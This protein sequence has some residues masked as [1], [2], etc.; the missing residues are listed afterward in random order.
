MRLKPAKNRT[1]LPSTLVEPPAAAAQDRQTAAIIAAV[2]NRCENAGGITIHI[3]KLEARD[4]SDVKRIAQELY[5][6]VQRENRSRGG[7]FL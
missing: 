1:L 2:S 7:G 5:Y 3:D 6:M 4:E